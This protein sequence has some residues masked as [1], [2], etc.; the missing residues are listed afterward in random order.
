MLL[1]ITLAPACPSGLVIVYYIV[2]TDCCNNNAPYN[3][4]PPVVLN[5][6][7]QH[8]NQVKYNTVAISNTQTKLNTTPLQRWYFQWLW[9]LFFDSYVHV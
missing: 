6:F 7:K 3:N 2:C 8:S 9:Q 4:D 5:S 1:A